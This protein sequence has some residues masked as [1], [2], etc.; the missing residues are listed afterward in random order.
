MLVKPRNELKS[1]VPY[2]TGE[3]LEELC[4]RYGVQE[5][6][7][8]SDNENPYG[9]SPAVKQ[10]I[11]KNMEKLHFYPDASCTYLAA[12]LASFHQLPEDRFIIGNGSDEIIRIL[13]RA[14]IN[15][16]DEAVMAA[17]TFPRYQTNVVIEGGIPVTVP[18]RDGIHD[19]DAMKA[20][21]KPKT[22]MVFICNPNN[23]TGT[24]TGKIELLNF[25]NSVPENILIVIDEAY[26]EYV[27]SIDYLEAIPL[28]EQFPNLVVLRTFSKIYGLA[29]LRV[30]YGVMHPETAKELKK[31]KDV[32]NI[33]VFAQ[34]AASAALM[35][36]TF[37]QRSSEDNSREREYVSNG[38]RKAG[39]NT[40]PSET[41]FLYVPLND[42]AP[43]IFES[44]LKAGLVVKPMPIPGIA[45]GMRVTLGH[46]E[47]NDRFLQVL[48]TYSRKGVMY[49]GN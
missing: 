3:T 45:N 7:K 47:T 20:K 16:N 10:I 46:R 13:T 40:L 17:A 36:Q 19:L 4:K 30:G 22:K 29:G 18:L 25:I 1:M 44:L 6:I 38:L 21:I 24:I 48:N 31:A 43:A 23:P 32:F 14:F 5:M 12:K 15:K 27:T 33:N 9:F 8:M 2:Q 34:A 39:F 28:V 49:H 11:L 37:V 35:D 26:A 42:Q 41:N